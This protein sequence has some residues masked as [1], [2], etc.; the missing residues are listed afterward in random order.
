MNKALLNSS[1]ENFRRALI[2]GFQQVEWAYSKYEKEAESRENDYSVSFSSFYFDSAQCMWELLVERVVCAPSERLV[3][4]GE[5]TDYDPNQYSH[6]FFQKMRESHEV[7]CLPKDK[8]VT[9]IISGSVINLNKFSFEY[10]VTIGQ[11]PHYEIAP[12]FEH[13]LLN[14]RGKIKNYRQI[15]IPIHNIQ[16]DVIPLTNNL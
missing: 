10:F 14:E 1:I 9:D 4:Y 15:L 8:N 13:I 11:K 2:S 12:P 7:I 5:G 6:I 3:P 16:F